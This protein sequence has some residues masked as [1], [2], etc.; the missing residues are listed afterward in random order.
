MATVENITYLLFSS[1][2]VSFE[3]ASFD[4]YKTPEHGSRG[5]LSIS[6]F[7]LSRVRTAV[8]FASAIYDERECAGYWIWISDFLLEYHNHERVA[9][10]Y[11]ERQ[12]T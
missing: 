7:E 5:P 8:R 9:G 3:I 6:L 12:G 11:S 10:I 1:V 4:K 2:R